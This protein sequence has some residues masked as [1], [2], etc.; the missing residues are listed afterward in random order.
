MIE[1][2]LIKHNDV[3]AKSLDGARRNFAANSQFV[4]YAIFSPPAG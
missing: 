1:P 2:T 3:R 4:L